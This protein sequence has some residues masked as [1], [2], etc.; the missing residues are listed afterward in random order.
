M[1][2]R[3]QLANA[4]RFLS[5]DAVQQAQSGHPGMPMGMA[6]IAE[7]LWN[8]FLSHNPL[9][10]AW[11]N[12]D[13]FVLSNGHGSMLLYSLLH[14]TGY[15]LSLEDLKKFRQLHSKTPGHPEVGIT[16]GVEATT[17][18]LGQGLA[19][20]VGMALAEQLLA[21]EFNQ[22]DM[23]IIN[24]YTYCFVGD[25]CLM[26]GIS[27]EVG[28]LA[29]TLGLGKLIVIWDDNGISIDGEVV[30]WWRDNTA[31]RFAAYGWHVIPNVNGHDPDAIKIAIEAA[32]AEKQKP[33]FIC[34]KTQIGFGA[35]N[36]VG[37]EKV[38]GSALGAAEIKA[39][40][41]QLNWPYEPFIIPD[42][43]SQA[44]DA[45]EKGAAIEAAWQQTLLKYSNKYPDLYRELQRRIAHVIP[46]NM[47]SVINNLL[48]STQQQMLN[49][50]TRKASQNVLDVLMQYLPELLGGSADLSSS[51][52]TTHKH[53][54]AVLPHELRGNYIYYGVREFGMAAMMNGIA[55]HGG[56]IP[57]GGTF[58]TFV[59]YA[60]NALRMSALMRQQVIY[61]FTH[62]SIGLGEDGP[63]HQPIEHLTML[64]VTPNVSVW[65]PCDSVE[66]IV[67]WQAAIENKNGPTC[68]CLSRQNLPT[69]WRSEQMLSDIARGGYI[70]Q[71]C[72][73]FPDAIII[74][75]GSEI[76]I[77]IN[78]ADKLTQQGVKVRVVSMPSVDTFQKQDAS[79]K[80]SVLPN[81]V[82]V[83]VVV[84]AG[85]REYWYQFVGARGKVIGLDSFGESAPYK[86]IYA[87]MGLTVDAVVEAVQKCLI[88]N[89]D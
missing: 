85:A 7:V 51:N 45:K 41:E 31:Q 24:H 13:R 52:L 80:A 11:F 6:D 29:G 32:R 33:T 78:A 82:E 8:D 42:E 71:D 88:I 53:M 65:R 63:T 2:T 50:A 66:T 23:E 10:P 44:W 40:R 49:I 59:D 68:L 4:L 83:R 81:T 12:R 30:N 14:L 16:P 73:D 67:A 62:D 55:L 43:I 56:F 76:E 84:E 37:T 18:P 79:Y 61:I 26:E 27:H 34:C 1:S 35:P 64:R 19:C 21:H 47:P 20:A 36:L 58:L 86:D 22:P 17:G 9:N 69:Y 89:G 28:S 60:R 72:A 48:H 5:I 39:T 75:T 77:A 15:A 70:L 87:A 25:G 46:D 74:A 54:H 57:Y 38:H 3:L